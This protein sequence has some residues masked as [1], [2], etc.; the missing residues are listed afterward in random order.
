MGYTENMQNA[1]QENM[2]CHVRVGKPG[3]IKVTSELS[4]T[5]E[6]GSSFLKDGR[7]AESGFGPGRSRCKGTY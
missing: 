7:E 4:E 5:A 3:C 1:G 6:G 2:C